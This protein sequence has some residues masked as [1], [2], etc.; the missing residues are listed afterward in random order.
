[1]LP[2]ARAL[3]LNNAGHR[4]SR[5]NGIKFWCYVITKEVNNGTLSTFNIAIFSKQTFN[6]IAPHI[7]TVLLLALSKTIC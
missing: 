4:S 2:I 6:L 7:K 3:L 1:M 5:D